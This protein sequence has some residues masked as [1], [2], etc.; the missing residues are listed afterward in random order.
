[1]KIEV[2]VFSSS[3]GRAY[4]EDTVGKRKLPD[5]CLFIIADGLGGHRDGNL[6]SQCIVEHFLDAPYE[7]NVNAEEWLV[8]QIAIANQKLLRLQEEKCS[9][10]KSTVV[11][12]LIQEN[13]AYWAHVGDSRLYYLHQGQIQSITDDHS[14]AFK[15]YKAGEIL[16]SQIGQDE[17]QSSLLRAMGNPERCT[18]DCQKSITPLIAGDGFM[19]CSDGLWTYLLDE[20]VLI[21]F[22]KAKEPQ[23]WTELLLLRMLE[24]LR[25]EN[26]NLSVIT[27]MVQ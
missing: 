16:R 3:G 1:M 4:N 10:M 9:R 7:P 20:E 6:A 18:P 14:V 24:R 13:Y 15:K 19:L 8:Q 12:L 22:L 25:P 11:V 23:E 2:Y 21:D 27:V 5:G 26:D 17:D